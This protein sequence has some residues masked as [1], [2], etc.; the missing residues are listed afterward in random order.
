MKRIRVGDLADRGRYNNPATR[1]YGP[2]K[3]ESFGRHSLAEP[4]AQERLLPRCD[5]A[6]QASHCA[7]QTP[8]LRL[9]DGREKPKLRARLDRRAPESEARGQPPAA[10]PSQQGT[11]IP[12]GKSMGH[13]WDSLPPKPGRESL[14]Q[15]SKRPGSKRGTRGSNAYR[16][17]RQASDVI[18]RKV[19]PHFALIFFY[20]FRG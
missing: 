1:S 13:R 8:K 15:F 20:L 14:P 19:F 10:W 12:P 11:S 7:E 4:A 17:Q 6:N 3:R 2:R 18:A 5:L 9:H 16:P